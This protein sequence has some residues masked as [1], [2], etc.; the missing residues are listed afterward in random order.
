MVLRP[1]IYT[2]LRNDNLEKIAKQH[3]YKSWAVLYYSDL[4]RSLRMKRVNPSAIFPGDKIILPPKTSD[5]LLILN[6]RDKLLNQIKS[7]FLESTNR[8]LE[9]LKSEFNK[10]SSFSEKIE[11]VGDLAGILV[12]LSKIVAKGYRSIALSNERLIELNKELTKDVVRFAYDPIVE[13]TAN[14]MLKK[15]ADSDLDK[16][17]ITL[18][19][20]ATVQALMD[21]T[22]PSF[23]AFTISQWWNGETWQKAV[24]TKP[25]DVYN[26]S[27]ASII[28]HR[29]K[30]ISDLEQKI[31]E[32]KRLI[33]KF[34]SFV[35]MSLPIQVQH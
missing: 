6:K 25:I 17:I 14:P 1:I 2:V 34:S 11:L 30:V 31:L 10:I 20:Q 26:R 12:G 4:N 33:Q 18:A 28:S 24:K 29:T 15:Y 3:G 21:I 16:N 19:S 27:K 35:D 7:Q 22:S 32:N 8:E 23:W 13:K 9:N 5:V